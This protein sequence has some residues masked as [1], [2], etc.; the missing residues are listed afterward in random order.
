MSKAGLADIEKK[1]SKVT[2]GAVVP[3]TTYHSKNPRL[4]VLAD[5]GAMFL[6]TVRD[7][8]LLLVAVLTNP[9]FDGAGWVAP[10]NAV[11][12]TDVSSL[13]PELRFDNGKG[14]QAPREKWAMSLQTPRVLTQQDAARLR[15]KATPS[16]SAAFTVAMLETT[17]GDAPAKKKT[18]KAKAKKAPTKKTAKKATKKATAKKAPPAPATW[19]AALADIEAW[20]RASPAL[21]TE[22][23]EAV[24]ADLGASR[25]ALGQSLEATPHRH[26]PDG[27]G[28]LTHHPSGLELILVPGGLMNMGFAGDDILDVLEVF[29]GEELEALAEGDLEYA[30]MFG[31]SR[32]PRVVRVSP[33]L[34]TS[35]VVA[36]ASLVD[37]APSGTE[38]ALAAVAALGFR[39]PSEAEWEWIGREGGA[40]SFVGLPRADHPLAPTLVPPVSET[41]GWGFQ[42]L[43]NEQQQLADGW[44]PDYVGAPS[45]SIAWE[46]EAAAHACRL[47]HTWW[48]SCEEAAGLHA[49][50]RFAGEGTIRLALDVPIELED[51]APL[52]APERWEAGAAR[53]AAGLASKKKMERARALAALAAESGQPGPDTVALA[54]R[55]FADLAALHEAA[56]APALGH[57]GRALSTATG[58]LRERLAAQVDAGFESL[59][60]LLA[61]KK[62]A[63][64]ASAASLLARSAGER[65]AEVAARLRAELTKERRHAVRAGLLLGLV[66][67]ARSGRAD[68]PELDAWLDHADATVRTAAL[69]G[70]VTLH[71]EDAIGPAHLPGLAA[72]TGAPRMSPAEMPWYDGDLGGAAYAIVSRLDPR[73]REEAALALVPQLDRE[74]PPYDLAVAALDLVF[75]KREMHLNDVHPILDASAL[76]TAQRALLTVLSERPRGLLGLPQP[77]RYGFPEQLEDRRVWLGMDP[78]GFVDREMKLRWPDGRV[79][80]APLWRWFR[81]SHQAARDARWTQEQWD[82]HVAPLFEKLSPVDVLAFS[83]EAHRHRIRDRVGRGNNEW[84]EKVPALPKPSEAIEAAL[85]HDRAATRAVAEARLDGRL[86]RSMEIRQAGNEPLEVL[87]RSLEPKEMIDPRYHPLVVVAS[88]T[89]K[90]ILERVPKEACEARFFEDVRRAIETR[91]PGLWTG[92]RFFVEGYGATL[93]K[94][95][96]LR[97]A[98]ALLAGGAAGGEHSLSMAVKV[99]GRFAKRAGVAEAL[100]EV[101]ARRPVRTRQDADRVV[102]AFLE[103]PP[104]G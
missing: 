64:R 23:V 40:T 41:N 57:L 60:E 100:A 5:G 47:G 38:G 66:E 81:V 84:V 26:G 37:A 3:V 72:A 30:G 32:P 24:A 7:D 52:D 54:G 45:T 22:A 49:A 25:A 34:A 97:N 55:L 36:P 68:P 67:L 39:L 43:L 102:A 76:T 82:A 46:P 65:G 71:G 101:E 33:F 80:S 16:A 44:H 12:V 48:Q 9:R 90:V 4:S 85:A 50:S 91:H 35:R 61:H 96:S 2:L 42:A 11:P 51:A 93:G 21:R 13:V 69:L 75:A 29:D 62:P 70:W 18:A 1:I 104:L 103:A 74:E 6:C 27:L 53:I 95:F 79:R 8:A 20:R 63:A 78:P 28:A 83:L 86:R 17:Q 98:R 19:Q 87:A 15:A 31:V 77:E 10:P 58:S 92:A 59:G 14:L 94:A 73:T 89:P 99:L 88:Y 56:L